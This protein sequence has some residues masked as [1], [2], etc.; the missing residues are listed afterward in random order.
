[1]QKYIYLLD[2]GHGGVINGIPQTAGKRSPA[3]EKGIL[4]EGVS[5]RDFCKRVKELCDKACINAVILVPEKTDISLK[6]RVKRANKY[7]NAVL[8]SIH[9]DAFSSESANGWSSFTHFG[10]TKSDAV[11]EILYKYAREAKLKIRHDYS[12]GDSDKE[13]NFYIL[14]KTKCP[15]VLIEN[16]FM[17]NK[18]D[19]ETLN[20][21][22]GREKLAQIIFKSIKEIE[23]NGI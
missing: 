23:K 5:N 18:K 21:E 3:W 11:A 8:L 4:Y 10:E 13:A 15:A 22:K 12:D 9:S 6:E 7:T 19:Y 14:S 16:L 17:T 2:P 20:S 1:M